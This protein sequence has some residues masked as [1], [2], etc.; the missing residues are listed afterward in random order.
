MAAGEAGRQGKRTTFDLPWWSLIPLV[1]VVALALGVLLHGGASEEPATDAELTM[2]DKAIARS[3]LERVID[4]GSDEVT[5]ALALERELVTAG[6]DGT[7]RVWERS[8]GE[9]L[10]E[11]KTEVPIAAF[12]ETE[13]SSRV[14]AAV[15]RRGG[16]KLLDLTDPGRP[17]VIPLS[18]ALASGE[19]PL[20]VAFS[21]DSDEIVTLGTRGEVL[22]VNVT[23][24]DVVSRSS[25]RSYRGELPWGAEAN[26]LE[27]TAAKFVPEVY[28]DDEGVLVATKEGA[29]VDVDLGKGQGKAILRAGVAPG[30]ILS[31]DR[32]PYA[33]PELAVGTTEGLVLVNEEYGDEPQ[34]TLGAPVP[35]VTVSE[36][37]LRQGGSE[38]LLFGEFFQRP[39]TG[40]AI[41][42]FE[43]GLNGTAVIHPAGRVSVLG[44]P[45]VGISRAET[46]TTPVM[47]FDAEDHLLTAEGYD[48]NHIEKIQALEPRPRSLEE[49]FLQDEV[50]QAYRPD[51]DWWP[52]AKDP[53]ALYLDDLAADERYV[54]AA[55]Q[56]PKGD[57]A[58][59]V[60]DAESGEPLHHLSLES[61]GA[62]S[63]PAGVIT[64]VALL[65]RRQE[66]AAYSAVQGLVAIWSTET[67][68]L[69]EAI[70]VGAVGDISVSPDEST[71]VAVGLGS[72]AEGYVDSDDR[73]DLTFVDVEAGEVKDQVKARGV[74]AVTFSPDGS[75]LAMADQSG[76]L[77]LRS[78]D[79]RAPNGPLLDVGGGAEAV[80]WRPD[81]ELIAVALGQSGVVLADPVSGR[82]SEPLPYE[83]FVPTVQLDWSADGSL[84]AALSATA[85][86]EGNFDPGP[87]SIWTLDAASL[88]R[89]MCELYPCR[90]A[91][92][93][94]PLGSQLGDASAL[95]SVDMVYR[96]GGGLWAADLNGEKARIGYVEG[97]YPNPPVAYDWS[98]RGLAWSAPGQIAVLLA[99]E[100]KPR[101]WTCACSGVAWDGGQI[102]SLEQG[103]GRLVRIGPYRER[104]QTTQTHDLPPY[105]PG[106][107]GI[108]NG[109]PIVT[110]FESEP[111]RGTPSAV[112]K[113]K[114]DGSAVELT[115]NAHGSI[116]QR[117]PSSS[118][119]SLAFLASLA[120]GVCYSTTNVGIVSDRGN[121]EIGLDFPPSPLDRERTWIRSLQ[122]SASGRVS[123][124]VAPIGCDD[125]G[126]PEDEIPPAQQYLLDGG[127]W[128]PTGVK[129][130]DVQTTAD[131]Q[132]IQESQSYS[133]PGK[134][135][136]DDDGVRW[137]V[138]PKVEGLVARP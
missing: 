33:N 87:A 61:G 107:L 77:R 135:F 121:G 35:A 103:E 49:D 91:K 25:L 89:R 43:P 17:R 51:R 129:G 138:A 116:Y 110:A 64:E 58:V 13:S 4:T 7:V 119:G 24:G 98:K 82:V 68:D 96:E 36:E 21:Q 1:V 83:P 14:L 73:T 29:V 65:P 86:E 114:A 31:L 133:E 39:P 112:F 72:D 120:G 56:D 93:G 55:G 48:A 125:E 22:R 57:A 42:R 19:R 111:N 81:G 134:L 46:T 100:K 122:V 99:G 60:W 75:T 40:P 26:E 28:E 88:N 54:V 53:E 63:D 94:R 44:S 3:G 8:S 79:G 18:V 109:T 104:L 95:A 27:L 50:V 15:D 101:S 105:L 38:G 47:A 52:K 127:R 124:A 5:A 12:A 6:D 123:A 106:L 32:V 23:T 132:L 136:V 37:G 66:I 92:D 45:G 76:F 108:V 11:T 80:A 126:Y 71:I 115:D 9:L 128:Q 113:I 85:D 20:T 10:G 102:L 84:L 130:F 131:V 59:L 2:L 69:E 16:V 117:W 67:W 30:R 97:E 137:E 118:P 74:T 41:V 62:A 70:P 34:V 90:Q 78:A